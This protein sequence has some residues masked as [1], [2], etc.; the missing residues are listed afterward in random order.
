VRKPCA[1]QF[2]VKDVLSLKSANLDVGGAFQLCSQ[3]DE[4]R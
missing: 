1:D 4:W 2:L 3:R